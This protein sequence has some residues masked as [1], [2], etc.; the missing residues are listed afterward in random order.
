MVV[1]VAW[2]PILLFLFGLHTLWV[3]SK[4]KKSYEIS[5]KAQKKSHTMITKKK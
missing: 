1:S 2:L 5:T 3:R 4:Q